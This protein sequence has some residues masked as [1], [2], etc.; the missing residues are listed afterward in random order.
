VGV[1]NP[2]GKSPLLNVGG[3]PVGFLNTFKDIRND[4]LNLHEPGWHSPV[5][6]R[7]IGPPAERIAVSNLAINKDTAI[8]LKKLDDALVSSLDILAHKVPD[9]SCETALRINRVG[10]KTSLGNDTV[11]HSDL[12]ILLTKGRRL[13]N[14]TNTILGSD[15]FVIQHLEAIVLEFFIEVVKEGLVLPSEHIRTLDAVDD[16]KL[17]LLRVLVDSPKKCLQ[18][19]VMFL[20]SLIVDLYVLEVGVGTQAGVGWK[21]PW[22]SGPCK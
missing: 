10:G 9:L 17:G 14:N 22:G 6:Q 5:D 8:A 15:I 18:K 21:C 19:D 7:G 4:R 12:V 13:V 3:D 2:A 1:P 11:V 20:C 16:L